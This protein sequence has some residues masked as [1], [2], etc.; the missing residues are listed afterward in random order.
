MGKGS[1]L[2]FSSSP[3]AFSVLGLARALF[4][5]CSVWR[6]IFLMRERDV[7]D[8]SIAP[9]QCVGTSVSWCLFSSF[10]PSLPPSFQIS[11]SGP[12]CWYIKV[13]V[14]LS[15][16]PPSLS[17]SCMV[18]GHRV[19]SEPSHPLTL[20]H[21]YKPRTACICCLTGVA[22]QFLP[23]ILL[24]CYS[25]SFP[26]LVSGS[27]HHTTPHSYYSACVTDI[28]AGLGCTVETS[29]CAT[30][31]MGNKLDC[32]DPEPGF[33]LDGGVA[34]GTLGRFCIVSSPSHVPILSLLTHFCCS[35][36]SPLAFSLCSQ[37]SGASLSFPISYSMLLL[38]SLPLFTY[39]F[40]L[41]L[42]L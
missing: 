34:I 42:L 31:T 27:P 18:N 22:D 14:F 25:S 4:L 19:Q 41:V 29:A 15:S 16:F 1:F 33:Y 24:C 40:L 12:V 17:P 20:T 8:T 13:L 11:H 5:C 30:N 9:D 21:T 39:S 23:N 7:M 32:T 28:G 3:S 35:C 37:R 26:V 6:A 36:T 38:A 2:A 10:P